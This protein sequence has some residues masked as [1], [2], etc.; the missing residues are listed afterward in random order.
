M[1]S[2]IQKIFIIVINNEESDIKV[3]YDYSTTYDSVIKLIEK[4]LRFTI[5]L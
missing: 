2:L 3:V 1:T 5:D 4:Q